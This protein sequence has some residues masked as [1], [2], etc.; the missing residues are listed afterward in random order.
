MNNYIKLY[1]YL[2]LVSGLLLGS[3]SCAPSPCDTLADTWKDCWCAGATPSTT[4]PQAS[5]DEACV[6]REAFVDSAAV[7]ESDRVA[8]KRC[9]EKDA[10]WA[11]ARVAAS[12][13]R[14]G[15]SYVCG[16]SDPQVCL[17]PD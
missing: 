2:P 4:R 15:G 9:D 8:I 3:L 6:S 17:P 16:G 13:C 1:I 10:E 5:I 11:S 12:E 7:P 14:E